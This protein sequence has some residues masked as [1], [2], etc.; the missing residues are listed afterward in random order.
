[1]SE[2]NIS[3]CS[4]HEVPRVAL[5]LSMEK[6]AQHKELTSILLSDL[7]SKWRMAEEELAI[8]F[9]SVLTNLTDY[10]LDSPDAPQVS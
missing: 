8:A 5:T 1:M 7:Y 3:E 9:N 2:L 10:C 4:R 6:K